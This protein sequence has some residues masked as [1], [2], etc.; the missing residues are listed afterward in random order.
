MNVQSHGGGRAGSHGQKLQRDLRAHRL[1]VSSG[2]S[3]HF[4]PA[5]GI[6][7]SAHVFLPQ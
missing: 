3:A 5:Q 6:V 7:Y 1:P 2:T 4:G